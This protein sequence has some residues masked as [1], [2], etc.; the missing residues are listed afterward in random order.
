MKYI[1]ITDSE[2]LKLSTNRL[3][4][5]YR[6]NRKYIFQILNQYGFDTSNNG[7]NI[8]YF[9]VNDELYHHREFNIISFINDKIKE[10]LNKRNENN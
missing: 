4:N 3:L 8:N 6:I 5:I 9:M 7:N 10:E 1:N 2:I